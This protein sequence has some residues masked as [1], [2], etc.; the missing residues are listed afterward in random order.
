MIFAPL[1]ALSNWQPSPIRCSSPVT[2]FGQVTPHANVDI[3][4]LYSRGISEG[5]AL[6]AVASISLSL[7]QDPQQRKRGRASKSKTSS[8][9]LSV[10]LDG[11]G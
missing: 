10:A 5:I 6:L 3:P 8:G 1:S 7:R 2:I 11:P 4:S 9:N